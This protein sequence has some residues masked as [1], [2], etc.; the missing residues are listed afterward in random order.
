MTKNHLDL[1]GVPC[2]VNFIRSRLALENLI[3]NESLLIY[4]DRGEPEE[5]V[6]PGLLKEGYLVDVVSKDSNWVTLNVIAGL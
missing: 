4:L 3:N 6:I 1:R 2:P 5:M